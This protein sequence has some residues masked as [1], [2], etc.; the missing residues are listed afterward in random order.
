MFGVTLAILSLIQGPTLAEVDAARANLRP[1]L[2]ALSVVESNGKDEAV[3]DNGKA[4][5]RYQ[6]WEIYWKDAIAF[7]PTI[8]GEYKNV[9]V[10]VYAERIVVAY[11]M[12][13]APKAVESQDWQTLARVHNGGP[14]G[15]KSKA[16]LKYWKKIERALAKN[17]AK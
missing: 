13:Y 14:R 8:E 1:F 5:G 6:I 4:L 12:R 9:T 10:R 16:T 7:A 3:G 11:L 17:G 15:H 2:D